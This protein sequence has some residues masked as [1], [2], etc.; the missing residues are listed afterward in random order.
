MAA[1]DLVHD[2]HARAGAVLTDDVGGEAGRFLGCRPRAE[3]LLDRDDVVVDR[4][5]QPDDREVV[6]V[7][8]EVRGKVGGRRVGVVPA[9]GVEHVDA[10]SLQPLRS[11][12]QGVLAFLDEPALDAVRGVRELHAAVADRGSPEA[13]QDAGVL[14]DLGVDDD[15][16]AGEQP[17]VPVLVGDDLDLGGQLC[18]ALDE[19]SDSGGQAGREATSRE[20]RDATDRHVDQPLIEPAARAGAR[21]VGRAL[22]RGARTSLQSTEV[23]GVSCGGSG[24]WTSGTG[25]PPGAIGCWVGAPEFFTP[26]ARR[27]FWVAA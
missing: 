18:V 1:H 10:V 4:L 26:A 11:D 17:V 14:A 22:L 24:T 19:P 21:R 8:L 6:A 27:A 3:G 25:R 16:V 5:R 20:E 23:S 13:V 15:L 12:G 7:L 9:D 2:E